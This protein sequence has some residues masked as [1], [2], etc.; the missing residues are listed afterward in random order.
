MEWARHYERL[1]DRARGR[2][3]SG[4]SER[5][6]IIP[7]CMG[8][9]DEAKNLVR[10]TPEEHFIAH[11]LL[12]KIHPGARGL[13]YSIRAL[14]MC[15]RTKGRSLNKEVGW[16][17]RLMA[18]ATGDAKRGIPR[19]AE[20]KRKNGLAHKG[21]TLPASQRAAIAAALKG[22]TKTAEHS[23]KVA[24]AL[25]GKPG[26]RRGA[27]TSEETK[28]KMREAALRRYHPDGNA[29]PPVEKDPKRAA[30]A[31]KAWATKRAK[32]AHP[33]PDE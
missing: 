11:L 22:K 24:A 27:V 9:S 31:H 3:L 4:Y 33:S 19:D 1:I 21:R 10:L 16:V 30:A 2:S 14:M 26:T 25:T 29:P 12:I 5:H 28:Q 8:G 20:T 15:G 32:A 7:R 23:A 13:I 18:K 17:R 6:H